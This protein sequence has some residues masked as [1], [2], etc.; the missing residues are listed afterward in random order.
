MVKQVITVH[1]V[2]GYLNVQIICS[3]DH[4]F[5]K[6]PLVYPVVSVTGPGR[7]V[8]H[9]FTVQVY[10]VEGCAGNPQNRC[11][12]FRFVELCTETHRVIFFQ[13]LSGRPHRHSFLKK[14]WFD[15]WE[16]QF[17]AGPVNRHAVFIEPVEQVTAHGLAQQGYRVV[18]VVLCDLAGNRILSFQFEI[19]GHDIR[20]FFAQ[21]LQHPVGL[22]PVD[23]VFL[24]VAE[25]FARSG[26]LPPEVVIF[27]L[28][29]ILH[30]PL[31]GFLYP[32]HSLLL[33]THVHH[34]EI[35]DISCDR[36]IPHF[37]VGKH[38]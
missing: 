37:G 24:P 18:Q 23:V 25:L 9:E 29:V 36:L 20:I 33:M 7:T 14:G 26:K 30:R 22:A 38:P 2:S 11:S 21:L 16:L 4:L 31:D 1:I 28:R 27:H 8:T 35:A 5:R 13:L 10:A 19:I 32:L 34:H 17:G 12:A 15:I 3:R 6:V